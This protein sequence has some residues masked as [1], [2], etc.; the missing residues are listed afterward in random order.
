MAGSA[1]SQGLR[2]PSGFWGLVLAS[3]GLYGV[4]AYSVAR[5]TNEIGIR[6]ALGANRSDVLTLVVGRGMHLTIIGVAA[7]IAGALALTRF[8]SSL[9]YVV[10]PADPL[11]FIVISL[12]LVS[13]AALASYIPACR[14]TKVDPIVALRYE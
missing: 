14:A 12:V 4:M 5:R 10:K 13:V 6:M 7:G 8:L 3:V 1:Q 11:T 2:L 9:L